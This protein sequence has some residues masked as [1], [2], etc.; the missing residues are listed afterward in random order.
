MKL[1]KRG[2][3]IEVTWLDA[4][5]PNYSGHWIWDRAI[6]KRQ[7]EVISSVGY[8]FHATKK[9]LILAG[10]MSGGQNGRV[11]YIPLGCIQKVRV[12]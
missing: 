1:P 7:A 9:Y 2:C 6:R 10:D 11:F 8:F 4:F 3:K 12:L 5:D